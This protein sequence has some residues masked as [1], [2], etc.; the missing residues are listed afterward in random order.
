M[1]PGRP[2]VVLLESRLSPVFL[3]VSVTCKPEDFSCGGRV[4][5]CI[6]NSW[7]CDGQMDCENGS[8][9]QGCRK[10]HLVTHTAQATCA[11]AK[12]LPR[13]LE[14]REQSGLIPKVVPVTLW[15]GCSFLGYVFG[16][17]FPAP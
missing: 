11:G 9:E 5:R 15:A 17:S 13:S 10:C 7:R 14:S 2:L 1:D 6:P 3:L 16:G 8:D 12:E 4:N